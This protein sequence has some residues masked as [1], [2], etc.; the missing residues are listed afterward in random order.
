MVKENVNNQ[1]SYDP[2]FYVL[3]I[4]TKLFTPSLTIS[5]EIIIRTT[6]SLIHDIIPDIKEKMVP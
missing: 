3:K 2:I 1:K 5:I 6:I 4:D